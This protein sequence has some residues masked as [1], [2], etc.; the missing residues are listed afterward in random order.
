M[1]FAPSGQKQSVTLLFLMLAALVFSGA[2]TSSSVTPFYGELTQAGMQMGW[3]QGFLEYYGDGAG[4][5]VASE[6]DLATGALA[7]AQ[8]EL[9]R[10]YKEAFALDDYNSR[11]GTDLAP[12]AQPIAQQIA[13]ITSWKNQIYQRVSYYMDSNT[14]QFVYH[15]TCSAFYVHFGYWYGRAYAAAYAGLDNRME[16]QEMQRAIQGGMKKDNCAFLLREAWFKLGVID[17]APARVQPLSF[18]TGN[19]AATMKAIRAFGSRPGEPSLALAL[20]VVPGIPP[21]TSPPPSPVLPNPGPSWSGK[22]GSIEFGTLTLSQVGKEV[23]GTFL[24]R[25]GK[26]SGTMNGNTLAGHWEELDGDAKGE[27]VFSLR[28]DGQSFDTRWRLDGDE[29]WIAKPSDGTK[30]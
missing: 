12:R 16:I 26:I 8:A 22:W 18:F 15:S 29:G 20:P 6:I 24:R 23:T 27:F 14:G 1:K 25:N 3:S 5:M 13:L 9:P 21:G 28:E 30:R 19:F 4:V 2:R 7:R 17:G 10:R 11:M